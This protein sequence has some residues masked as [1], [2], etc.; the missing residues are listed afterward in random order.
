MDIVKY[1]V[2][3][4]SKSVLIHRDCTLCSYFEGG[5][6]ADLGFEIGRGWGVERRGAKEMYFSAT[7][8]SPSLPP[9]TVAT[10]KVQP[11]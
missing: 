2:F 6:R 3:G 5:E 4:F 1:F 7:L 10:I 9:V 8:A 11:K